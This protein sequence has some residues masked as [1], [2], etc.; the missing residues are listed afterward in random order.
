MRPIAQA[1][2][3]NNPG[4]NFSHISSLYTDIHG[5]LRDPGQRLMADAVINLLQS[6]VHRSILAPLAMAQVLSTPGPRIPEN[7]SA[8]N[9]TH[10][11]AGNFWCRTAANL[12]AAAKA[13]HLMVQ[14]FDPTYAL[15]APLISA[16]ERPNSLCRVD[17]E[18]KALA[19]AS[20]GFEWIDEGKHGNQK[21]GFVAY[22]VNSSLALRFS[23]VLAD[24]NNINKHYF[25]HVSLVHLKSYEQMGT[26][27]VTCVSG[28]SCKPSIAD[29]HW[30]KK[31]SQP[32]VHMV[33]NVTQHTDCVIQIQV[34]TATRSK[35]HK[36]K[37]LGIVL[38]N[39]SLTEDQTHRYGVV[40]TW[41]DAGF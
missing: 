40:R 30:D 4:G 35:K 27:H 15:P 38:Q 41:V 37:V 16:V 22:T 7:V 9:L 13:G 12:D 29:G 8:C 28:C 21:F 14:T 24:S 3:D 17:G 18:L 5:H 34:G 6:V 36:F 11:T 31:G 1:L 19:I 33:S 20:D 32:A 25:A 23:T 2:Y 10:P 26:A 39:E